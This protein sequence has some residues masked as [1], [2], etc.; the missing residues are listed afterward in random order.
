MIYSYDWFC[1]ERN[2]AISLAGRKKI[3]DTEDPVHGFNWVKRTQFQE[4]YK[5]VCIVKGPTAVIAPGTLEMDSGFPLGESL[6]LMLD[7][8]SQFRSNSIILAP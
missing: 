5:I 2:P 4:N 1:W 3:V 8:A 6:P 7:F